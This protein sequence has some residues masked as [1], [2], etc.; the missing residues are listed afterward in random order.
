MD[1]PESLQAL[2]S[3][4]HELRG[5]QFTLES[6]QSILAS[7]GHP[8]R[9]YPTAIVAGTNGKGSTS[10]MLASIL[11][12][13]GSRVGLYTSPH[14]MHVNERVRVNGEEISDED[15]AGA[16]TRVWECVG[17]LR[18][19][20]RLAPPSFFEYLT[21]TA[22]LHFSR[23]AID[24]AVLEVGMGG[25][26]DATNVT[27][28]RVAVVTNIALDHQEFLGSTHAA[29]AAEKAGVIQRGR[30]VVS[31]CVHPEAAEVIRRR[32]A[33]LAAPLV[34]TS[35]AARL[36]NLR[37]REGRYAFDLA[38]GEE[39]YKGLE[40]PLAG[41]FQ[42][43]NALAAVAAASV[44]RRDGWN[45]PAAAVEKGLR[46][47]RWPARLETVLAHPQVVLD[48]AH[49]PAAAREIADFV[50]QHWAGRSLRLI[51]ASMRDKAIGEI[52][53]ILFPLAR[54]IYLTRPDQAR[55][56]SP[57]EILLAARFQHPDVVFL[58]DPEQ[59]LEAAVGESAP[60]DV[61]L[62]AGS[63]FLAGALKKALLAKLTESAAPRT[64][65]AS[66]L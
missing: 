12:A 41:R 19:E 33:E 9:A 37:D 6:I 57:Q 48:G 32:A 61:V 44:L 10:A 30:P 23:A 51:Y 55:A 49:N 15:F 46:E 24:F 1:Y 20:G 63:L 38:F 11:E 64:A 14:L 60:E 40:V 21:A 16:F 53:E 22:F 17:Q 42:V 13:A 35:R 3:L 62:A 45:I 4:G 52:S 26:L 8:E 43:W 58:P 31:A 59:A 5:V 39:T 7:L 36:S 50:R 47:A 34:E 27:E 29:I 18:E 25:R 65:S 66:L 56:A 2:A 54:R 28:P